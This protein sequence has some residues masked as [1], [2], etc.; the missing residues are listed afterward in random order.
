[1]SSSSEQPSRPSRPQPRSG[2]LGV[3]LDNE[4]GHKRITRGEKFVLVGGSQETHER[5]TETTLKTFEELK[6]RDKHLET[7]DKREL[8]EIIHK[9]TPQ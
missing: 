5:M 3:G 9:S 7:V 1:M 6:R 2:L 8:A 4:D